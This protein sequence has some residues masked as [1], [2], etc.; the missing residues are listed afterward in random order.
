M[1]LSKLNSIRLWHLIEQR[2]HQFLS[3]SYNCDMSNSRSQG[4]LWSIAHQD[5]LATIIFYT[6]VLQPKN[7]HDLN[8]DDHLQALSQP[9]NLHDPNQDDH[10]H[11]LSHA[12]MLAHF[13]TKYSLKIIFFL[14]SGL[15][16][17]R[18]LRRPFFPLRVD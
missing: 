13:A 1:V 10:L 12:H 14:N 6:V 16:T 17:L 11:A 2:K 15:E 18:S 5:I 8:Q 4:H 3:I 9:K 7:L